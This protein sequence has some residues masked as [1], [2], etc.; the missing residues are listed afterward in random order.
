MGEEQIR[1]AREE[2]EAAASYDCEIWPE[3]LNT[4]EVFL[5]MEKQ[6]RV[7]VFPASV[8]YMS[9]RYEALPIVLQGL[10]L[11]MSKT[12]FFGLQVMEREALDVLNEKV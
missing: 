6:W 1:H 4:V 5:A 2:L 3:N 7:L 11:E 8:R 10:G 9:L 12:L